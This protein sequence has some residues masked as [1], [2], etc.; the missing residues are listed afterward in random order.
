MAPGLGHQLQQLGRR[1]APEATPL[2]LAC[3]AWAG[4]LTY[5]LWPTNPPLAWGFCLVGLACW[6]LALPG[7]TWRWLGW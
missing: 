2:A 5:F 1:L 7:Q 4:A 6:W 3:G